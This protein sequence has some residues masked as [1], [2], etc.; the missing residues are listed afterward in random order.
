MKISTVT[1]C[2]NSQSSIARTIESFLAQTH[3]DWVLCW[4]DDGSTD[5]TVTIL[6][7]FRALVGEALAERPDVSVLMLDDSSGTARYLRRLGVD[8]EPID[9]ADLA[10]AV[11]FRRHQGSGG[12]EHGGGRG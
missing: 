4:R 11:A 9:H 12:D 6:E 7:R 5:E 10:D 3:A 1:V 8:T 2:F